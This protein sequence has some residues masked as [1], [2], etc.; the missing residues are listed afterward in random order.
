M[1]CGYSDGRVSVARLPADST[2]HSW[3]AHSAKVNCLLLVRKDKNYLITGSNDYYIKVWDLSYGIAHRHCPILH[4]LIL[5]A[6][7]CLSRSGHRL[8]HTFANHSGP[9][10][11]L[12]MVG[13]PIDLPK[14]DQPFDFI[15]M[16]ATHTFLLLLLLN[17]S[18]P[19]RHRFF[20]IG[21]DRSVALFQLDSAPH[22]LNIF[23]AH[24][25]PISFVKWRPEQDY[26]FV[27]CSDGSLN[28]WEITS[29]Q[30][31]STLYG[32]SV[33]DILEGAQHLSRED[34][35]QH[36]RT[37]SKQAI[38][39]TTLQLKR[40]TIPKRD[41]SKL[42]SISFR[43]TSALFRFPCSGDFPECQVTDV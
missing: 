4:I 17:C 20:S 43:L 18:R 32:H 28:I 27:A 40:G 35:Q 29:G 15:Y 5:A 31:E 33:K 38:T 16:A 26:L 1:I 11:Q 41:E 7:V 23:G 10:R 12:F 42:Y 2:P 6:F 30:L 37:I 9:V 3:S 39:G 14:S 19:W 24:A 34:K 8:V 22:C 36:L 21:E 25:A 13:D